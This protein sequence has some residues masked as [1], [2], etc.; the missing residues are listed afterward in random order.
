MMVG[1]IKSVPT[2]FSMDMQNFKDLYFVFVIYAVGLS[3]SICVFL[4]E[5]LLQNTFAKFFNLFKKG[6][7]IY[8]DINKNEEI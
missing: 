6:N 4:I 8:G 5:I 3:L 2:Y 7:N 1:I